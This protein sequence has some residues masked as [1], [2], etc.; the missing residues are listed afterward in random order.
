MAVQEIIITPYNPLKVVGNAA[1]AITKQ[2]IMEFL[3]HLQHHQA[4]KY[5]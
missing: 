5:F 2:Y 1:Y 4:L 3:K